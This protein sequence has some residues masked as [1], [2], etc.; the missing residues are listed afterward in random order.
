M[1]L[2]ISHLAV[3]L[4]GQD[5]LRS[6]TFELPAR[7]LVALIGPN[8]SGKSTLLDVLGG[9][10]ANSTGI[11]AQDDSP[12][13]LSLGRRRKLCARLHQALVLPEQLSVQ[14]YIGLAVAARRGTSL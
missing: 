7:G 10:V 9:M 2:L 3:R 11:I 13:S 1:R 4:G 14:E 6:L 8:G 12:G 5:V